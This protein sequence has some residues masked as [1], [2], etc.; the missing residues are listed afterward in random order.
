MP[1]LRV[2]LP[3]VAGLFLALPSLHGCSDD[4]SR[5][6]IRGVARDAAGEPVAGAGV[7]ITYHP[8]FTVPRDKPRTGISFQVPEPVH[9]LVWI[10]DPCTGSLVRVLHDGPL[11]GGTHL[12]VWD[13]KDDAGIVR[14]EGVYE[15]NLK[16]G[17]ARVQYPF[18][19]FG[20][21]Y[22][23]L[24][25]VAGREWHAVTDAQGRFEIP[26]TCLAFGESLSGL[27]LPWEATLWA[28][29]PDH[30]A[31]GQIIAVDPNQG[32]EVELKFAP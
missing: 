24:H 20:D 18:F 23:P 22:L 11:P 2:W 17:D 10:T 7:A 5:P 15:A 12:M 29:H 14:V 9:G 1:R 8:R 26:L 16:L 4:G 27:E 32:A 31:T 13:G 6:A 28:V 3:L 19:Y 21:S 30:D 25:E